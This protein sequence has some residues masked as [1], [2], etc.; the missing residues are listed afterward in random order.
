MFKWYQK[1]EK[2]YVFLSD[3][4][5]MGCTGARTN[6]CILAFK[7]SRWFTRGWTLQELLAPKAVQ[8]FSK[9]QDLLG[10]KKSMLE[11]VSDATGISVE[12]IRAE[13]F[14]QFSYEERIS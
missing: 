7:R 4:S 14:F 1:A 12:A 11:E 6:E 8:F 13:H 5:S 3:V 10:D 9:E 2:C